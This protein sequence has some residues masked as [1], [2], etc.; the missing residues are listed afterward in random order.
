MRKFR[1]S[2]KDVYKRQPGGSGHPLAAQPGEDEL[3]V[4]P[5]N[6]TGDRLAAADDGAD[7]GT[8]A[9]DEMCIRDSRGILCAGFVP[10]TQAHC[11]L[12]H[13][14]YLQSQMHTLLCGCFCPEI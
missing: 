8:G 12:E 4:Q 1:I 3:T 13:Y 14:A 11:G 5:G 7:G 9:D 6:G 10:R 2:V